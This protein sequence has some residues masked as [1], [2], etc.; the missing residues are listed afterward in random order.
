[1]HASDNLSPGAGTMKAAV[2]RSNGGPEVLSYEDVPDPVPGPDEVLV[3]VDAV[4]IEGGDL[5]TRA[6]LPLPQVPHCVGYS[7]AG[8]ITALGK[9]VQDLAVGQRVATFA[10]NG[11]HAALRVARANH[12]WVLPDGM[13]AAAAACIPVAFGTAYEA[14]FVF[15]QLQ[16]GQTVLVQ[17]A[18]GGVGLAGLQLARKAGAR[19]I[20]TGSSHEQLD[21]LRKYGLDEGIDYRTENLLEAVNALTGGLGVDLSLDPVGGSMFESVL[22]ATRDGGRVALVGGSSREPN[23]V[24][25]TLIVLRDLTVNGF[26]LSKNF[27]TSRVRGYVAELIER[28]ASGD[29]EVVI[30]R[31]FPLADVVQAHGYAEQ[32]GRIG[33]VV[34]LP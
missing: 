30:D 32:R 25:A 13:D 18:A 9:D 15:G 4:A 1:M 12:C 23:M 19:V 29:L 2:Y 17:G 31:V 3:R 27:H 16:S 8:E 7:A 21:T 20:G 24:N 14:L 5:I 6:A 34:M 10:A 28:V 26:M 33:R 11:S 22:K